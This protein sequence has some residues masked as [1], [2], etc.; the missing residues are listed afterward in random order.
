MTVRG[1]LRP[2]RPTIVGAIRP[3]PVTTAVAPLI[4]VVE[5]FAL[6]APPARNS[7]T[8]PVTVTAVP[9]V[10]A[11]SGALLVNTKTPSEVRRSRSGRGSW[12]K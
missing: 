4:S 6:V 12:M 8:R 9:G 1:G 5:R 10:S 11:G 3:R 7:V 2:P